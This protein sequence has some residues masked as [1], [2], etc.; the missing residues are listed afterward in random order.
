MI[1]L[2]TYAFHHAARPQA[3]AVIKRATLKRQSNVTGPTARQTDGCHRHDIF[4]PLAAPRRCRVAFARWRAYRQDV[5]TPPHRTLLEKLVRESRW[6]IEETCRA[7]EKK[8]RELGEQASLSPRQLSRWMSGNVDR[9]RP[10]MQR[11]AEAFWGYSFDV[12]LGPPSHGRNDGAQHGTALG[13]SAAFDEADRRGFPELGRAGTLAMV[14]PPAVGT[15][16]DRLPSLSLSDGAGPLAGLGHSSEDAGAETFDARRR[17]L[18]QAIA[19]IIAA[20]GLLVDPQRISVRRLGRSDVARLNAITAL[21][22]SLDSECGSGVLYRD[23][24]RFAESASALLDRSLFSCADALAPSLLASVAAARQLAGWTA[25]D[26]GR[27]A[28]AQRHLLSAERTAV[29]A[30]DVRLAANVRYAQARQFQHLHHDRDAVDTLRLAR[31][32][33]G[34]AATPAIS[35]R[36]YGTEAT[37]LAALGNQSAALDALGEASNAFDDIKADR[38]PDWMRFYDHGELLAEHAT[39]HRNLARHEPPGDRKADQAVA[40]YTE[41]VASFGPQQARSSVLNE[42]GLCSALFLA[43]EPEQALTVG[44]QA[45]A[46]ARTLTSH[47][48]FDRIRDLRYDLA[49]HRQ[50]PDVA[51]F[52]TELATINPPA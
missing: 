12:L 45:V 17:A 25:F 8:A 30:G 2:M 9:P 14:V 20:S 37:S 34:A 39:V 16:G 35:A 28:D 32:Q 38:E 48:T 26:V 43:D 6:T 31:D 3:A 51:T 11:V 27:H 10:V 49:P 41:A 7:F 46:D 21:Y 29:A 5:A 15:A 23:L 40:W 1:H 47:R 22:R 44:I 4:L 19:L 24:A 18:L 36:L 52:D 50:R 42:I 33:L 13:P